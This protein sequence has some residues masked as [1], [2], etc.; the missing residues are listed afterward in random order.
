MI[1]DWLGPPL[2]PLRVRQVL[3]RR[4]WTEWV[5]WTPLCVEFLLNGSTHRLRPHVSRARQTRKDTARQSFGVCSE[6]KERATPGVD[7]ARKKTM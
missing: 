6:K 4:K 2:A 3:P 5:T 1:A 7:A